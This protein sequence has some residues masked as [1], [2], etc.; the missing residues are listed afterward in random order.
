MTELCGRVVDIGGK[1]LTERR[2]K[3][4]CYTRPMQLKKI[5]G[6]MC[7]TASQSSHCQVRRLGWN[8]NGGQKSDSQPMFSF[9][10]YLRVFEW[11]MG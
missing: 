3:D 9:S 11:R 2:T 1:P 6:G 8:G 7:I 5:W 10:W 4:E